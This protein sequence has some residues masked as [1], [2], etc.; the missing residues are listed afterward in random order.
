MLT[1]CRKTGTK[2]HNKFKYTGTY[3]GIDFCVCGQGRYLFIG[4]IR[5]KILQNMP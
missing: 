2:N 4:C 1:A 3:A 5:L